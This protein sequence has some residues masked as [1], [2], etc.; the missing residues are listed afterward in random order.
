MFDEE[1][2][3][4]VAAVPLAVV[5]H[6]HQNPAALQLFARERKFQIS[7]VKSPFRIATLRGPEAAVPEHDGATAVLAL[8]DGAFE[9]SVV[10]WVVLNLD[11]QPAVARIERGPLGH[12]PGLKYAVH[13]ETQIVV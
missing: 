12:G 11:C 9:I 5:P 3:V 10:E 2:V 4:A 6:P 1:P 13:L 7:L 8:R